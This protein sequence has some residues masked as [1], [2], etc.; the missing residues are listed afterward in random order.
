MSTTFCRLF[1]K[2]VAIFYFEGYNKVEGLFGGQYEHRGKNIKRL[3]ES[4]G[5]TQAELGKLAGASDKA[6]ST[7]ENDTRVPRMG[8]IQKNSRLFRCDKK[9]DNR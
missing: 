4:A 2:F 5:L 9:R 3:R 6:V 1:L 8:S 7:W